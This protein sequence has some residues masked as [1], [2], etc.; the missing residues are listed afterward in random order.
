MQPN[1]STPPSEVVFEGGQR[2][3]TDNEPAG[4]ERKPT[5]EQ[6]DAQLAEMERL[7]HDLRLKSYQIKRERNA[8]LPLHRLPGEI[9]VSI[10]LKVAKFNEP[11]FDQEHKRLHTLAQVSTYWLDTI[12]AFPSFW[13]QLAQY[14]PPHFR[15]MVLKRN[16][17][18][19]LNIDCVLAQGETGPASHQLHSFMR[20]AAPLSERWKLLAFEGDLTVEMA[21]LLQSPAPNLDSLLISSWGF[22]DA[23]SRALDLGEGRNIQYLDIDN[24]TVPWNSA[25]LCGLRGVQ[26]QHIKGTPPSLAELHAMLS[27][28]PELWWLQLSGWLPFDNGAALASELSGIQ[29]QPI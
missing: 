10:L 7:Q 6:L 25:R 1:C 23:G 5:V 16:T 2:R 4:T 22:M 8:L 19:L 15:E 26:I 11:G 17:S 27:A 21:E 28:S 14:H 20:V 3:D 12:L 24:I 9:F 29:I 13:G 18:G